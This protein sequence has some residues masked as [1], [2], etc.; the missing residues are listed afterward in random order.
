MIEYT[1]RPIY[2]PAI[3]LETFMTSSQAKSFRQ[4]IK[5]GTEIGWALNLECNRACFTTVTD[6]NTGVDEIVTGICRSQFDPV[7]LKV[8]YFCQLPALKTAATAPGLY[9]WAIYVWGIKSKDTFDMTFADPSSTSNAVENLAFYRS[10]RLRS[11]S[12]SCWPTT[13]LM[14]TA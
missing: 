2:D 1:L 11:V 3:P 4:I 9:S 10:Q 12:T 5:N 6:P 14:P 8:G 7:T 13:Q